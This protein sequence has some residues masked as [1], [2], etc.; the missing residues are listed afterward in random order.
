MPGT[1]VAMA[2]HR[3][4]LVTHAG[5]AGG[6]W[7]MTKF[8]WNV[9]RQNGQYEADII[10]LATSATDAESARLRSPGTWF[11]PLSVRPASREI[12]PCYSVGANWTELEFQRYQPRRVLTEF[13]QDYDLVQIIAGTP[14]WAHVAAKVDRPVALFV[15]T[16]AGQE[17]LSVIKEKSGWR[18]IWLRAMT[19]INERLERRVLN[20]VDCVFA[21]SRYTYRSLE[22]RVPSQRLILAPVGVDIARFCPPETYHADGE[23]VC[24]ARL[25]DPRK[26]IRLLIQAYQRLLILVPHAPPLAL[27]GKMGITPEDR[28]LIGALNLTE[29]VN[30]YQDFEL[31]DI[32]RFYQN[33]SL[34][35]LP[36]DEEGLGIVI[37]E[38]MACGLPVV[39]TDCGGPATAVEPGETGHLTPVGDVAALAEAIRQ[40]IE[41]P[42]LRRRMGQRGRQV[43][44][45]TFSLEAAGQVF[46]DQYARLLK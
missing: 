12:G 35:V 5:E 26:N 46:L 27:V 37:L 17:R 22:K 6:T 4:A 40:L 33:A 31:A 43:V 41:N 13:L 30:V 11:T 9:L 3:I 24:V 8:V 7:A 42:A 18:K 32:A 39:S 29:R 45:Q 2:K 38:A 15:A 28:A 23:I 19:A 1:D 10:F 16:L 20:D 21:L 34:F 36:S 25:T 14:A 44:E